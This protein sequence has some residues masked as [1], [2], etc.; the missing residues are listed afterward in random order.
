MAR[1]HLLWIGGLL[2][3]V[4]L[5]S[6]WRQAF[7][8]PF[9]VSLAEPLPYPGVLK[10]GSPVLVRSNQLPSAPGFQSPKPVI[11]AD[12]NGT[13]VV[14]AHGIVNHP[15]ASDILA[16]RSIDR[17][18]TW[19]PPKNLTSRS[20]A[21]DFRFDPWIETDRRG[22]YYSVYCSR[23][24]G[25]TIFRRSADS[26]VSWSQELPI[27]WV[28]GD[29]PVLGISPNG[30]RIVI[31][32]SMSEPIVGTP[33]TP[34]DGSALN[35]RE[36]LRARFR[37]YSGVFLSNDFGKSWQRLQP[38]F[39]ENIQA[40]PFSVVIDNERQIAA[41]WIVEGEDSTSRISVT[42]DQGRTWHNTLLVESLQSDRPHPFN[43]ERFPVIA[44]DDSGV[45]HTAFISAKAE[46]LL[47]RYSSDG[48]TWSDATQHSQGTAEEVRMAA[49]DA[50][51]PMVHVMW[52]ERRDR[53]WQVYYRGS[54]DHGKT[55]IDSICLSNSM[56]LEN[57]T[58]VDGFQIY[59]DDD[60]SC[61]RD[62]GQGRVHAVWSLQ[63]G[64][65]MQAVMDWPTESPNGK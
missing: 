3:L 12:R 54:F 5:A 18:D 36:L 14:L 31:A 45:L 2:V 1:K 39:G 35:L 8:D 30:R 33:A 56:Q 64:I 7:H 23:S 44:Q 13:V 24:D 27:R 52:M 22:H 43:G 10:S 6:I 61:L 25:L 50:I 42:D 63:G 62:D 29:R 58:T 55:W 41:A 49:I 19:L 38:P 9:I 37:R 57:G 46:K 47:T 21:G 16:W 60:Q 51:G 17:G 26:G 28:H 4:I 11:A 59:G 32:A 53:T 40:I 34:L 48:R 15:L 65:V 20:T